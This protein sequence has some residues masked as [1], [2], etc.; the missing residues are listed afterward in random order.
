MRQ[1]SQR[2]PE[3]CDKSG[4]K[5]LPHISTRRLD[6]YTLYTASQLQIR[7]QS[8]AGRGGIRR[9][10]RQF[11]RG[12]D[13]LKALDTQLGLTQ[14]LAQ[15]LV[16]PRQ[17]GKVTHQGVELLRQRVFGLACGYADCNDA[18]RLGD[19]PIHKLLLERDPLTGLPLAA[20]PTLS[21]FENAVGP[22]ELIAMGHVLA[23]TVIGLEGH[24]IR[25]LGHRRP[26]PVLSH[27]NP[28][29]IRRLLDNLNSDPLTF[30][31]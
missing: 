27:G 13:L 11:G 5:T 16:D 17:P 1:N 9:G 2:V 24:Y 6:G 4:D 7:P 19:D 12:R 18:A 25:R 23:D 3:V 31:L 14:R 8:E 10:P 15:C 20:Q 30:A 22:R 21:R 26:R 29:A 28:T